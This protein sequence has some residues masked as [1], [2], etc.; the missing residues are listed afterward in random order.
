M[1][2]G[3]ENLKENPILDTEKEQPG[4]MDENQTRMMSWKG[5]EYNVSN[6]DSLES[7]ITKKSSKTRQKNGHWMW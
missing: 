6:K 7:Y 1:I 3:Q 2:Y 4:R 5:R